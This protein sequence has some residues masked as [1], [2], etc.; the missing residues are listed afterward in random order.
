MKSDIDGDGSDR[1][2]FMPA[3]DFGCKGGEE[4]VCENGATLKPMDDVQVC[5]GSCK[6]G[7][8]RG[9]VHITTLKAQPFVPVA[10]CASNCELETRMLCG[11]VQCYARIR[12]SSIPA[13]A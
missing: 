1:A 5:V 4:A 6:L 9:R 3:P 8:V 12:H 2:S 11:P 13:S 7:V 10:P